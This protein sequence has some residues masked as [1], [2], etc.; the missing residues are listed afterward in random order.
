VPEKNDRIFNGRVF[1][2][3]NRPETDILYGERV[4]LDGLYTGFMAAYDSVIA[5]QTHKNI[6]FAIQNQYRNIKGFN[7]HAFNLYI[8]FHKH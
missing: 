6:A 1:I 8:F 5:G 4:K 2:I 3:D 7:S